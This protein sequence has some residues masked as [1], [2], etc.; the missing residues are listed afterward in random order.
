[1]VAE[2]GSG[3]PAVAAGCS[4]EFFKLRQHLLF[5]PLGLAHAAAGVLYRLCLRDHIPRKLC[6]RAQARGLLFYAVD[7]ALLISEMVW[8]GRRWWWCRG[9]GLGGGWGCR[10]SKVQGQSTCVVA[11]VC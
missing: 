8:C 11:R 3:E 10:C 2:N 7:V 4:L 6:K 1:M 5:V 9:V